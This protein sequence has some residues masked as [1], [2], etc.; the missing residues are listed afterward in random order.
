[1]FLR[2]Y[3]VLA[4]E[5]S[6]VFSLTNPEPPPVVEA[7]T[8]SLLCPLEKVCPLE[9]EGENTVSILTHRYRV[10]NRCTF[11]GFADDK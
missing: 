4:A 11:I 6:P 5:T 3:L 7:S 1:M 9:G 2:V 10:R 8:I